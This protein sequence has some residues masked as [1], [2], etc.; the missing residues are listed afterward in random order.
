M[1]FRR[2]G[3]WTTALALAMVCGVS[4]CGPA[5]EGKPAANSGAAQSGGEGPDLSKL[6]GTIKIDG[7]STVFP[8]SEAVAEEFQK[9]TNQGVKVPVGFS[10]TGGGF[11]KFCR[12]EIDI[13]DAS[14]PILKA[15]VEAA[16]AAGIEYIEIPIC[17]DALTVAVHPSNSL[18]SITI[19]Q[20]K[21]IWEPDAGQKVLRWNQVNPEW[22]DEELALFGAG[23]DSGT[24]D[25]FTE[26]VC[27]KAKASRGDFTASEDDNVLVQ[28][29]SGNKH[30]LGYMPFSYY[31]ENKGKLKALAVDWEKGDG[32]V[33]P[34]LDNVV[35][36]KYNPLARP[37]FIYV[38]RQAAERPE[39]KAFVEFY[40]KNA[41]ELAS[42]VSYLPLPESAYGMG[43]E[44]FAKLQVGSGFG[45]E[46]E[47]GLS[48]EEIMKR[49]PR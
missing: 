40:L 20:L 28:G 47:V 13:C 45:G 16:K 29:I 35:Q 6:T 43:L 31:D 15:E 39:V 44:R 11:K 48:I 23:A 3:M 22:P 14:R 19:A 8:V 1:L 38:S 2:F 26:A 36:G 12:G 7:S 41:R 18:E 46:P 42:E 9:A 27:G 49:T 4:G 10:G 37:L 21:T 33:A 24:F 34:S 32:P 25:Y 5:P 17:F 30:A